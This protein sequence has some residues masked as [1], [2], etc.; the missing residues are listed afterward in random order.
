MNGEVRQV[1]KTGSE[2]VY[3]DVDRGR[4]HSM[5][6]IKIHQPLDKEKA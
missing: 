3:N 6:H 4:R 2:F 1:K 5:L